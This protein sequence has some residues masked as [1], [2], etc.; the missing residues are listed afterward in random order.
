[1]L[2]ITSKTCAS[3]LVGK[4]K[5]LDHSFHDLSWGAQFFFYAL[6]FALWLV[7]VGRRVLEE[8]LTY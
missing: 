2:H 5:P 6:A 1:M 7:L 8:I 3:L 4:Q